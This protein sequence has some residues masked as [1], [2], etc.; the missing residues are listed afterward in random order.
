MNVLGLIPARGGSKG[1]PHKNIAKLNGIPLINYTI[2]AAKNS[3]FINKI[4]VSTDD[5]KIAKLAEEQNIL[6]PYLRPKLIS[7]DTSSPLEVIKH[8]LK[9]L[10]EK[11]NY[12][13]KII[14]YLQPTSPLRTSN[15]IDSSIKMLINSN[16]SSVLSVKKISEHPYNSFWQKQKFLKPFKK[17]FTNYLRR[18]DLPLLYYPTGSIYTF[19]RKT[20]EKTNSYY[21]EKILPYI[22]PKKSSIDIDTKLDLFFAESILKNKRFVSKLN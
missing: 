18:Q 19:W 14:I 1:I 15:M 21:G 12:K 7:K 13:P 11:E 5:K 16:A 9:L 2:A 4:F 22:L 8:T 17:N 10:D 6:V 20:I 3:K